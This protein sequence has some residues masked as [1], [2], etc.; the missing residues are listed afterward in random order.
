MG[1][2]MH[3]G[4]GNCGEIGNFG[5]VHWFRNL[6]DGNLTNVSTLVDNGGMDSLVQASGLTQ[7]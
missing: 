2:T 4:N 5:H 3:L 7:G 1:K 6:G